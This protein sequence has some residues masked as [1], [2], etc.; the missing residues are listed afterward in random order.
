MYTVEQ[1]D[2]RLSGGGN[3]TKMPAFTEPL[4][5]AHSGTMHTLDDIYA[6]AWPARVPKTGQT[7]S[8]AARDDGD[9]EKGVAWPNPRSPITA[10]AR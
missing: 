10:R 9:L 8:Y 6:L 2:D 1:I 7:T 3:A 4:L 5:L